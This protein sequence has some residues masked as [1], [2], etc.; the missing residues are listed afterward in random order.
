MNSRVMVPLRAVMDNMGAAT[1]FDN[2]SRRAT[3]IIGEKTLSIAAGADIMTVTENG[4]TSAVALDS[5]AYIK[6]DRMF[7]PVRAVAEA[8][9]YD[10]FWSSEYKTAVFFDKAAIIDELNQN[11]SVINKVLSMG[12]SV[13]MTKNYRGNVNLDV[14][15]T[16]FDSVNGD[17]TYKGGMKATVLEN[18]KSIKM[19]LSFD[20]KAVLQLL[21]QYGAAY[22]DLSDD[23]E[24][25]ADIM[26]VLNVVN[27]STTEIIFD[28]DNAMLYI[29]S[30]LLSMALSKEGIALDKNSWLSADLAEL[31]GEEM[32]L[33]GYLDSVMALQKQGVTMGDVI[34][35][36]NTS[37]G[38]IEP[39]Y[40]YQ[41]MM[42]DLENAGI[43]DSAFTRSGSTYK[44]SHKST[45]EDYS[46]LDGYTDITINTSGSRAVSV[47]GKGEYTGDYGYGY[48]TYQAKFDFSLS[49]MNVK[50][51]GSY[52]LKNSFKIEVK[53]SSA[54]SQTASSVPTAP[55][56]SEDVVPLTQLLGTSAAA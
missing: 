54:V 13:D 40:A 23:D 11:Y 31:T 14:S 52:H 21:K 2:A 46:T 45:A 4:A 42:S 15:V 48:G 49:P 36:Q 22:M 35:L 10:V 18:G 29:K 41:Y 9:G 7:V 1:E 16:A 37:S 44:F 38:W 28:L 12:Q 8:L 51:S 56:A 3:I 30:E 55:P 20:I 17:K 47:S 34:Y 27:D 6:N 39:V 19:N 33:R 53:L 50:F 24:S 5:A 25:Y 43:D 26:T 32:D